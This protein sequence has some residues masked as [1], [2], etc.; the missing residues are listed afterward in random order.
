[1]LADIRR[2][3]FT[4]AEV[5]VTLGII[6][7]VA[8]LTIPQLISNHRKQEVVTKL[9]KVYSVMNQ[10]IRTSEAEYGDVAGWAIDC[11]VPGAATCTRDEAKEWFNNYIGKNIQ[12]L[13]IDDDIT[14]NI[15]FFIYFNDG[16]IL[17]TTSSLIDWMYYLNEKAI[18][19]S[20]MGRNSFSFRFNPMLVP[21]QNA[22]KNKY[23]VKSTFEPYAWNW[24][25]T[26]EG[27]FTAA[28]GYGCGQSVSNY[29][30][31]LIQYEGWNIPK[32]YPFK[33]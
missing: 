27:L 6:G 26:R 16:S 28:G 14:S 25:G 21:G 24:D 3:A 33:F 11:G 19:N 20:K 12:I 18:N 31:K 1:M 5:L 29:C 13:K 8:A 30:T 10:A 4:L 17:S 22:D 23:T 2:Y 7:V 15:R 9:E 32:D